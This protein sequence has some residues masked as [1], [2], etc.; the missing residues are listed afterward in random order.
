MCMFF[1]EGVKYAK[2]WSKIEFFVNAHFCSEDDVTENLGHRIW[3]EVV[4]LSYFFSFL[5]L[6]FFYWHTIPNYFLTLVSYK[7]LSKIS[8]L[9]F[10][11]DLMHFM[12]QELTNLVIRLL[13]NVEWK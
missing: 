2:K 10:Y 5:F 1:S 7:S 12:L 4:V 13:V 6:L 8:K 11:M 3:V 9:V